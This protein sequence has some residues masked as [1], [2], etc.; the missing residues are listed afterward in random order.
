MAELSERKLLTAKEREELVRGW[1][2]GHGD[3]AVIEELS[4][5]WREADELGNQLMEALER[6]R[7]AAA[8]DCDHT[9]DNCCVKVGVPCVYCIADTAIAAVDKF[10]RG[11]Q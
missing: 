8:C 4:Q 11:K 10:L 3:H 1:Y 9:D 6:C 7:D 5:K 2:E